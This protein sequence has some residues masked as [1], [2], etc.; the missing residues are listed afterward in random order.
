MKNALKFLIEANKLKTVPRTGW[1]L[2]EVKNP[3]SIADHIFR[4][5][6]ATWLMAEKANLDVK[7]AIKIAL[8]HD[9]C[10]VYAGDSTPFGYYHGLSR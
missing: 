2:M 10:E 8:F 7:R 1:V 6:V 9:L 4:V 3:E 5:T